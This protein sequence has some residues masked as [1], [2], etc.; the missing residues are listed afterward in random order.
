MVQSEWLLPLP[1]AGCW[2]RVDAEFNVVDDW[3]L[4][5]LNL[6]VVVGSIIATRPTPCGLG[7]EPESG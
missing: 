7:R 1:A 3:A 6:A 5:S 2:G 4:K